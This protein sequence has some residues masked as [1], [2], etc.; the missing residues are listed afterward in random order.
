MKDQ[1]EL[2]RGDFSKIPNGMPGVE[3]RLYLLC[4]RACATARSR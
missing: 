1:K 4:G 2:G 3:T